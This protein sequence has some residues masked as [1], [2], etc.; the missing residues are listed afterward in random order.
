MDEIIENIFKAILGFMLAW[1]SLC[2]VVVMLIFTPILDW[3]RNV[4]TN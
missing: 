1:C 2:I 4:K 3:K